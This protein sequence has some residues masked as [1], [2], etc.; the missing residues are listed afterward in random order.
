MR[1]LSFLSELRKLGES[2]AVLSGSIKD[3]EAIYL[4]LNLDYISLC[5]SIPELHYMPSSRT[6]RLM[7]KYSEEGD[8]KRAKKV[9][10]N[11]IGDIIR[12]L[13]QLN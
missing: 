8:V 4:K 11:R 12:C 5:E 9:V 3:L 6:D 10:S 7:T 2:Q 1:H 13:K